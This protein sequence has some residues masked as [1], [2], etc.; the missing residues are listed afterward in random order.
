MA[1]FSLRT[2]GAA[3]RIELVEDK[4]AVLSDNGDISQVA[5]QIVDENGVRV[6]DADAEVTFSIAGPA[7]ILGIGNGNL[8][9]IEDPTALSPPDLRRPRP[10]SASTHGSRNCD[11]DAHRLVA[12]ARKRDSGLA[13]AADRRRWQRSLKRAAPV[14]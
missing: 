12:R 5:F 3:K 9:D 1:S 7:R 10:G 6:T 11:G 8:N 13:A 2:A 4:S 14:R